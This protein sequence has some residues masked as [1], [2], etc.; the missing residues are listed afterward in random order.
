MKCHY[1]GCNHVAKDEKERFQHERE[2]KRGKMEPT[3]VPIEE[4]KRA[5]DGT[6]KGCMIHG[7]GCDE[8]TCTGNPLDDSGI[9]IG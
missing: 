8:K 5:M 6:M 7:Y 1:A 2:H 4:F 3:I 9:K